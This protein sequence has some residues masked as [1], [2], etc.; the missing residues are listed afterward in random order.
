MCMDDRKIRGNTTRTG[1][2][3]IPR[4][5]AEF[6]WEIGGRLQAAI[7]KQ[8]TYESTT[9]PGNTQNWINHLNG[10]H[11]ETID[12]RVFILVAGCGL[13]PQT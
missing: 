8:G 2:L 13:E 3:S 6:W 5:L 1:S 12:F 7:A 10:K 9:I 11:P 4:F